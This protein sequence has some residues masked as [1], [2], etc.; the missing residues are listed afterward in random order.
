MPRLLMDAVSAILVQEPGMAI[1]ARLDGAT[2]VTASVQAL[3]PDV[4]VL[5]EDDVP[6]SGKHAALFA[7]RPGLKVVTVAGVGDR[8]ALYRMHARPAPLRRPSAAQLVQAVRG[9]PP[10]RPA[11]GRRRGRPGR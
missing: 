4:V 1:V 7:A 8:G 2:D 11:G 5:Q 3:Q 9:T 6:G 10:P